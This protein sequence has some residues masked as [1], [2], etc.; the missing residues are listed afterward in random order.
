MFKAQHKCRCPESVQ[1]DARI[2]KQTQTMSAEVGRYLGCL[3]MT[4]LPC[5]SYV[6]QRHWGK[7]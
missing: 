4:L 7:H 6:S 5:C 1:A 2:I 3:P